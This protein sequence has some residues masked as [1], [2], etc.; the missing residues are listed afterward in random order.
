MIKEGISPNSKSMC[1][2]YMQKLSERSLLEQTE[3]DGGEAS[4]RTALHDAELQR[5]SG[6]KRNGPQH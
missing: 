5:L 4:M 6:E 2:L 3:R 1:N